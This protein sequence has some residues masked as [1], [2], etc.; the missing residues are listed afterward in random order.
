MKIMV[1]S[2][3]PNHDGLT[4]ACAEA[5]VEGARAGGAEAEHVFLNDLD[6]GMCQA[7]RE[8]WGA[9]RS[10]HEC[11]GVQDDF[12]DLHARMLE[13]D[14]Y[15][16]VTPVYWGEQSESLKAFGDRLRRSEATLGEASRL[17]N[18]PFIAVGAAGGSGNGT[19]TCLLSMERWIQHMRGRVWDLV[20][21]KRW[22]RE[23]KLAAI[24][25]TSRRMVKGGE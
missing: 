22:T 17:A 7:C 2:S 9:C 4:A 25:D 14:G 24:K 10:E 3:S 19:I 15:V 8:G 6:V 13:A 20:P 11:R 16:I 12:Q 5:A 18:K 23:P 21:V 1:I